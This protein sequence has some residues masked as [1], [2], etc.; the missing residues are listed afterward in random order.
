MTTLQERL[1]AWR[2]EEE[3]NEPPVRETDSDVV[4]SPTE[5]LINRY[6]RLQGEALTQEEE[7]DLASRSQFQAGLTL[8]QEEPD[9]GAWEWVRNEFRHAAEQYRSGLA[10][11]NIGF[12]QTFDNAAE[13]ASRVLGV[14]KTKVFENL[15]NRE[16]QF[17][18]DPDGF[19][20]SVVQGATAMPHEAFKFILGN[21]VAGVSVG[22]SS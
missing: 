19:A 20:D 21:K 8:A 5:S 7:D 11:G 3:P 14:D 22:H 4:L 16:V 9:A 10:R 6:R 12:W 18:A 2:Q 1:E 17:L 13:L 15:R